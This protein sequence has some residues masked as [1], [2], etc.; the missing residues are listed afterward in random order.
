MPGGRAPKPASRARRLSPSSN[1]LAE[2]FAPLE[3]R[4]TAN[5]V[6]LVR[7]ARR[8]PAA[9]S[10]STERIL[11]GQPCRRSNPSPSS[12]YLQS[13]PSLATF[14]HPSRSLPPAT[15]PFARPLSF[16][17]AG[18]SSRSNIFGHKC[19]WIRLH[20]SSRSLPGPY[21]R[22]ARRRCLRFTETTI[23]RPLVLL[24]RWESVEA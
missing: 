16:V 21:R 4:W 20:K 9:A 12:F 13:L 2:R 10:S 23:S 7:G 24:E 11:V 15:P 1:R 5:R 17:A 14:I 3:S 18:G 22:E 19:T 6:L 8:R